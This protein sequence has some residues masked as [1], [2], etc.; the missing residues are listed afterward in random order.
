MG[1]AMVHNNNKAGKIK[2][3]LEHF[4]SALLLANGDNMKKAMDMFMAVREDIEA[5]QVQSRNETESDSSDSDEDSD[6]SGDDDDDDE[7]DENDGMAVEI[8]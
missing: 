4:D 7:E 6:E 1:R 2:N 5:M 8:D 3:I